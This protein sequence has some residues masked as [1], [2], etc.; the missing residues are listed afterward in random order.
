MTQTLKHHEVTLR[1]KQLEDQ[2]TNLRK[3]FGSTFPNDSLEKIIGS[4][5]NEQGIYGCCLNTDIQ[6]F[7]ALA[8]P[9]EPRILGQLLEKYRNVL[10]KP[11]REHDGYIMDMIAD[12]MLAVWI[13]NPDDSLAR[14]SMSSLS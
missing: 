7:C 9:M 4:E 6:G 8:E 1:A 3:F 12:S 2:V 11:I 14:K 5:Q 13:S 10:K